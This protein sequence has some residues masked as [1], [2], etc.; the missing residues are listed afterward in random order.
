M[1]SATDRGSRIRQR[2]LALGLKQHQLAVAAKVHPKTVTNVEN[3][4]TE[5]DETL[6]A[7]EDAL[8]LAEMGRQLEEPSPVRPT[9]NRLQVR[10]G[11]WIT[12]TVEAGDDVRLGDLRDVERRLRRIAEE[13]AE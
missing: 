8:T 12:Y 7:L 2:R 3:G 9:V 1:A 4:R 6:Q 11:V 10:P 13:A 5:K